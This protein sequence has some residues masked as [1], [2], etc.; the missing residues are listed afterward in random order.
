M[1]AQ[2]RFHRLKISLQFGKVYGD[3]TGNTSTST[4]AA[5]LATLETSLEYKMKG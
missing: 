2:Y 3:F 4:T 5:N 1:K